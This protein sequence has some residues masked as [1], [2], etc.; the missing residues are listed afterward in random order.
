MSFTL[1]DCENG[2]PARVPQLVGKAL[3]VL[4][5]AAEHPR[6]DGGVAFLQ[7]RRVLDAVPLVQLDALAHRHQ[8]A[9]PGVDFGAPRRDAS[10]EFLGRARGRVERVHLA[11]QALELLDGELRRAAF[12]ARR[13]HHV[14]AGVE[15][16][17]GERLDARGGERRQQDIGCRCQ[18]VLGM[19]AHE[20]AIAGEGHI[21]FN[22]ARA[23]PRSGLVRL[24]GVLGKLQRGAAVAYGEV[25]AVNRF[26]LA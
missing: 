12:G 9:A 17:R 23:H 1:T 26:V 18:V 3:R 6:N 2:V 21:A 19:A 14:A 5:L 13:R 15:G 11:A 10:L 20:R 16:S 7:F 8:R 22:D 25:R 4:R 24:L